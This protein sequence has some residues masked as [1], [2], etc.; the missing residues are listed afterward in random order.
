[1]FTTTPAKGN[2]RVNEYIT[3]SPACLH[4]RV[5]PKLYILQ[6]KMSFTTS[7]RIFPH[8]AEQ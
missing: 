1:V 8:E 2:I 7:V 3:V 6:T 5:I 4:V